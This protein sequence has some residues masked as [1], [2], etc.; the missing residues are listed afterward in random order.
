LSELKAYRWQ[1]GGLAVL[2]T[3]LST[4]VVGFGMWLVLPWVG[5]DLP[6]L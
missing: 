1:I 3:L 5:L 2:G 4:L 6:L